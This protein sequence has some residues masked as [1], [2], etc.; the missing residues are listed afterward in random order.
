MNPLFPA[1]PADLSALSRD[2][3]AGLRDEF[4]AVAAMIAL[5][6]EG[7]A[8]SLSFIDGRSEMSVLEEMTAGVAAI[9]QLTAA[10]DEH[11]AG[12]AA[13]QSQV[14]QLAQTAGVAADD[15]EKEDEEDGMYAADGAEE[16]AAEAAPAAVEAAVEP[17]AE[18]PVAEEAVVAAA[19]PAAKPV[20]LRRPPAPPIAHRVADTAPKN[21]LVASAGLDGFTPGQ[22]LTRTELAEAAI[23]LRNR[24]VTTP[25]GFSE[26]VIVASAEWDAPEDRWLREG[27]ADANQAKIAA[28][29]SEHRILE[30]VRTA[31]GVVCAPPTPYYDLMQIA[32]ARRPV[33]DSL[34]GFM[35]DRGGVLVGRPA[36]ISDAEPAITVVPAGNSGSETVKNVQRIECPPFEQYDL[37]SISRILEFGNLPGRTYPELV[38]QWIE[39]TAAAHA[40]IAEQE[41]LDAM[42]ASATVATFASSAGYGAVSTVLSALL[43]AGIGI[44]NSL[45]IRD[46]VPLQ[47]WLPIWTGHVLV[48]DLVNSQFNRFD[49][50]PEGAARLIR[51]IANI[52][53]T[54]YIDEATGTDQIIPLTADGQPIESYPTTLYGW[55]A[56]ARSLM[57]LDGGSLD[58]GIV[59]DSVLNQTNDWQFFA[60]TFEALAYMGVV[61]YELQVAVCPSGE[62][63]G[64]GTLITC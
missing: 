64:P 55:L 46:E 21:T 62:T 44:R 34:V 13:F 59:R 10:I 52:E 29:T 20:R 18:A 31:S 2:E 33:R 27:E 36:T 16:L 3:L 26:K 7:D 51:E 43:Q 38:A 40:R 17:V 24:H 48:N 15:E 9:E 4:R 11:D 54:Y 39:L 8:E 57:F 25:A 63:G 56:P 1:L 45:R 58:L 60:E 30:D 50:T 41:L 47:A 32:T 12:V 61:L 5:A 53:V 6:A 42:R 19:Q 22:A 37:Q 35:A 23:R 14:A 28:L 49:R